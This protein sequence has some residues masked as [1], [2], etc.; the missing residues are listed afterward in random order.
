[1]WPFKNIN[2]TPVDENLN[3]CTKKETKKV[4][5]LIKNN[6]FSICVENDNLKRNESTKYIIACEELVICTWSNGETI[7]ETTKTFKCFFMP[8][9][10]RD[11]ELYLKLKEDPTKDEAQILDESKIINKN[12]FSYYGE[13]IGLNPYSMTPRDSDEV[14]CYFDDYDKAK[15]ALQLAKEHIELKSFKTEVIDT[16]EINS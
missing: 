12:I 15:L 14:F 3:V 8:N 6:Y 13:L 11:E 2:P 5:N 1:M 4:L 10:T 16:V 9:V 7:E